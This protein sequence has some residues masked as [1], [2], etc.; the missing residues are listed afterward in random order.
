MANLHK[1]CEIYSIEIMWLKKMSS[2]QNYADLVKIITKLRMIIV[3]K[4]PYKNYQRI[5][6][7]R[8]LKQD[9]GRGAVIMDKT[10]YV[11]QCLSILYTDNFKKNTQDNTIEVET[12]VQKAFLKVKK[13]IGVETYT[14]IYPSRFKPRK[15][16]RDC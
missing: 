13:A 9:K 1:I 16:L 6:K 8:I 12:K 14:K 3:C 4:I 15:I 7:I 11:E 10:I 2:S 5:K